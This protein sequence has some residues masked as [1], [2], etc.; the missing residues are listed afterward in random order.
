MLFLKKKFGK[1]LVLQSK[2]FMILNGFDSELRK[3][4]LISKGLFGVFNSSK[5]QTKTIQPGVS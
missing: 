3:C 5:K 2:F 1:T 4:Q